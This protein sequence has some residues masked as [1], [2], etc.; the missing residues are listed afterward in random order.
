MRRA[1]GGRGFTLAE[2]LVAMA[3]ASLL[4]TLVWSF[5]RSAWLAAAAQQARSEAQDTAHL[6]LSVITRDLRQA[7]FAPGV[8][9]PV[10]LARAEAARLAVRADLNGDGDS[11]DAGE[12][13]AYQEDAARRTL[14]RAQGAASAQP[15]ADRLEAGSLRFAYHD[16]SGARIE[17]GSGGLAAEERARVR[18]VDVAFA[19][20]APFANGAVRVAV[21]ASVELRNVP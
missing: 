6:A 14:T 8:T 3:F 5:A 17:P 11:D 13:A 18:R 15:L 2:L 9:G 7:G 4:G 10:P 19:L 16:G 12:S 21:S 20:L 1:A